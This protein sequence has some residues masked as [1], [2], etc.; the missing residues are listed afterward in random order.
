MN[1]TSFS[2]I[3]LCS[4]SLPAWEWVDSSIRYGTLDLISVISTVVFL[5]LT[6]M[7]LFEVSNIT[8]VSGALMNTVSGWSA[9]ADTIIR[10]AYFQDRGWRKLEECF[11]NIWSAPFFIYY[12]T[13]L[14][15]SFI[16]SHLISASLHSW[17]VSNMGFHRQFAP[18]DLTF[19]LGGN[20]GSPGIFSKTLRFRDCFCINSLI[21]T[22]QKMRSL[23]DMLKS[24]KWLLLQF[25]PQV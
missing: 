14:L 13:F 22:T 12:K 3:T 15:S 2:S 8:S 4:W 18:D 19:T 6:C 21:I 9:G 11:W 24:I 10:N 16:E 17:P 1:A 23:Q 5:S 20:T 7:Y 25:T